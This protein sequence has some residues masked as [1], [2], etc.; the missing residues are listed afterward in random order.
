MNI[1][2]V[3][4]N[5]CV[6]IATLLIDRDFVYQSISTSLSYNRGHENSKYRYNIFILAFREK[7]YLE[8]IYASTSCRLVCLTKISH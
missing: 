3:I 7:H 2:A 1:H 4:V 6:Y 5:V 8:M